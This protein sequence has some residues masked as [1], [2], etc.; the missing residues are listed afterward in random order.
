[1]NKNI[2]LI[3]K[4]VY[5][6]KDILLALLVLLS[7]VYFFTPIVEGFDFSMP[8]SS[9]SS[10]ST[11]PIGMYEYL[12]PPYPMDNDKVL[13][14]KYT[15]SVSDD[16]I[17]R[18]MDKNN[19]I[20]CPENRDKTK[21][22]CNPV[23]SGGQMR[24]FL[25]FYGM[26][27][28]PEINYYIDNG[29]WP[30]NQF[31]LD[32]VKNNPDILKDTRDVDGKPLTIEGTRKIMPVRGFFGWFMKD[33]IMR[34]NNADPGKWNEDLDSI[35]LPVRIYSGKA[36]APKSSSGSSVSS[37]NSSSNPSNLSDSDYKNLVSLCKTVVKNN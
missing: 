9:S 17:N 1:M 11:K 26:P 16:L 23:S 21:N 27:S 4:L 19:S 15:E 24:A 30:Y 2:Y 8:S 3:K 36:V 35:P 18:L 28:V 6:Y 13:V 31:V 32:Y 14:Q 12:S 37:F 29:K 25:N 7:L 10:S 5:K 33:K 20:N 34:D 22:K